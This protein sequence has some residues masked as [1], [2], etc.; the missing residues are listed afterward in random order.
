MHDPGVLL[1]LRHL[2]GTLS[3]QVAHSDS[4]FFCVMGALSA[5][6]SAHYVCVVHGG[7]TW[8]RSPGTGVTHGC[9]LLCGFW[10]LK[11]RPLKE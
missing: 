7:Q 3:V 8:F 5:C 1:S 10:K 9:E 2:W 11:L 6:M 4:L